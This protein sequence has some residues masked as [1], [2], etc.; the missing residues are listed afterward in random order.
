MSRLSPNKWWF[1]SAAV[2][3]LVILSS[4]LL[5]PRLAPTPH[6]GKKEAKPPQGPHREAP[7]RSHHLTSPAAP[8]DL[9]PSPSE[10]SPSGSAKPPRPPSSL[11]TRATLAPSSRP[12]PGL[13]ILRWRAK[14]LARI[15]T[16][17][18]RRRALEAHIAQ[19]R[20]RSSPTSAPRSHLE[21]EL[22]QLV[23][24]IRSAR[25]SLANP[26]RKGS[27]PPPI[28]F[29]PNTLPPHRRGNAPQ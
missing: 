28:K 19:T 25:R 20:G 11:P 9:A 22:A 5:V 18:R 21:K 8:H 17:D 4:F 12:G 23:S 26:P 27:P 6:P 2:I 16:L 10:S 14:T 3:V 7:A 15:A 13:R 29:P 1:F 24:A